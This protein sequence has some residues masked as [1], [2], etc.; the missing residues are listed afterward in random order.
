MAFDLHSELLRL[1]EDG[2]GFYVRNEVP[3]AALSVG[4][5]RARL[6]GTARSSAFAR[7][8]CAAPRAFWTR[9]SSSDSR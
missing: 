9:F 5:L 4:D 3:V 1:H 7:I 8:E 6:T 2:A